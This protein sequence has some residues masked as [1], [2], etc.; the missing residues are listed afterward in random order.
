MLLPVHSCEPPS[1]PCT[2]EAEK[3]VGDQPGKQPGFA[4]WEIAF[5]LAG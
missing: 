3:W 2:H 1:W 4:I 5:L